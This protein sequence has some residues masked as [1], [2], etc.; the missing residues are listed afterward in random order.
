MTRVRGQEN[1]NI[2]GTNLSLM[3][4]MNAFNL[5]SLLGQ[6]IFPRLSFSSFLFKLFIFGEM[7]HPQKVRST[8]TPVCGFGGWP[9]PALVLVGFSQAPGKAQWGKWHALSSACF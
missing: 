3:S 7:K 4:R 6:P 5:L 1:S 9:K 8:A 2:S